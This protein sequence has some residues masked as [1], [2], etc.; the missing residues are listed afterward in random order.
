MRSKLLRWAKRWGCRWLVVFVCTFEQGNRVA[1]IE[2]VSKGHSGRSKQNQHNRAGSSSSQIGKGR[3]SDWSLLRRR[4]WRVGRATG[5]CCQDDVTSAGRPG[6]GGH[7]DV[8][9]WRCGQGDAARAMRPGRRCR[10]DRARAVRS[11]RYGQGDVARAMR[12][13]RGGHG[14]ALRGSQI[15]PARAA[16]L[17]P[18]GPGRAVQADRA[19]TIGPGEPN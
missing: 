17:R 3:Q 7:G 16:K 8:A 2:A 15:E 10:V 18:S 1:K 6:R 5:R 14:G 9:M 12:P 11:G 4:C 13:R 19:G